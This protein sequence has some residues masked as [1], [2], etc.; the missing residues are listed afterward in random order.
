MSCLLKIPH[1]Y[2]NMR[3]AAKIQSQNDELHLL[4]KSS[5]M[6][7]TPPLH[8]G[9]YCTQMMEEDKRVEAGDVYCSPTNSKPTDEATT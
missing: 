2:V 4:T 7:V 9:S 8:W 6:A 1:V 5:A 3:F